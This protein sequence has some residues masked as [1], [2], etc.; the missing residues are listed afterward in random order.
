M[1]VSFRV[2]FRNDGRFAY[3]TNTGSGSISGYR[4]A[5]D[6]SL[7]LRDADGR[8]GV[9]GVGSG[10]LDMSLSRDGR[11]LYTLNS[12]SSAIGAFSV[13]KDGGLNAHP[14]ISGLPASANGLAVR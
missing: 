9:T 11:Y 5:K 4:I 2:A 14:G 6:G 10:P 1:T 3:T 8:T 7:T 13:V 12:G